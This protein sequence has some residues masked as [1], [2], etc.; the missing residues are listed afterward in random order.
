MQTHSNNKQKRAMHFLK[1]LKNKIQENGIIK[2]LF[3]FYLTIVLI[4]VIFIAPFISFVGKIEDVLLNPIFLIVGIL[5]SLGFIL[6][7]LQI[8][9]LPIIQKF[10]NQK[11]FRT[12]II[13]GCLFLLVLQLFIIHG[14]WFKSGWDV[15]RITSQDISASDTAAYL[16]IFPNQIFLAGLFSKLIKIANL[17]GLEDGY[18]ILILGSCVSVNVSIGL[19]SFVARKL[20]GG[21]FAGYSFFIIAFIFLGLSPW[22]LVPYSD[23][24]S[25]L[26]T[27]L[28]LWIFTCWHKR[29]KWAAFVFCAYIGYCIKPT[30]IFVALA[31]IAITIYKHRKGLLNWRNK[32]SEIKLKAASFLKTSGSIIL[33]LIISFFIVTSISLKLDYLNKEATFSFTHYLMMGFNEKSNGGFSE[34]DW[35]TDISIPTRSEREKSNIREFLNRINAM[36][37]D[38]TAKLLI[39]KTCINYSDGSFAWAGEG[40]FFQEVKGENEFLKNVY[41]FNKTSVPFEAVDQILWLSMLVGCLAACFLSSKGNAALSVICL[42][43]LL[44]SVFLTLFECR[45]RYLFLYAPYYVLLG[46]LGWAKIKS[47]LA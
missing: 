29:I 28:L 39:K 13:V 37:F 7:I 20:G 9:K 35:V 33:A 23:T 47:R 10:L 18:L 14:A 25:M 27:S 30:V 5:V 44:L 19:M 1:W 40:G 31:V 46:V 3:G 15:W 4:L 11:E 26:W 38:G 41:G 24:Y 17:F 34:E 21:G 2:S 8:K 43:L 36:G 16:S 12:V 32:K 45:A 42:S 6:F 22:F